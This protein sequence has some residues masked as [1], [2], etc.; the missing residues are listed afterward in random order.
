MSYFTSAEINNI[1]SGGT[2][3]GQAEEFDP[4]RRRITLI[5]TG[6]IYNVFCRFDQNILD[7]AESAGLDLPFSCRSGAC[8]TCAAKKLSGFVDQFDQSF[9]DDNQIQAG[10]VLLCVAK[11]LSDCTIITEME[12]QVNQ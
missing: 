6:G 5:T 7:A 2:C 1:P 9:L 8:A 3:T 4:N 12:D 11:P 10:F